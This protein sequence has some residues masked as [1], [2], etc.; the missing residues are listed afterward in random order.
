MNEIYS[1]QNIL[2]NLQKV[3]KIL[4]NL[5]GEDYS[6]YELVASFNELSMKYQD[7]LLKIDKDENDRALMKY[8]YNDI[9]TGAKK[10]KNNNV[11]KQKVIIK[12]PA[13][14]KEINK[15][16]NDRKVNREK[17]KKVVA[18]SLI[19]NKKVDIDEIISDFTNN[20]KEIIKYKFSTIPE[21]NNIE[22]ANKFGIDID[23]INDTLEKVYNKTINTYEK[24]LTLRLGGNNIEQ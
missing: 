24:K 19:V 4:N 11:S 21:K 6:L 5:Y 14:E 17:S 16:K 9:R 2:S 12:N 23:E 18:N 8:I 1:K 20:E 10:A 7:L 15:V 13:Y 22:I 3:K